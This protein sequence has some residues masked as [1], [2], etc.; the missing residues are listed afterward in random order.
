MRK[1]DINAYNKKLH[2]KIKELQILV[3][4]INP[5][6]I[7][8]FD[9]EVLDAAENYVQVIKNCTWSGKANFNGI[10]MHK[11]KDMINHLKHSRKT[12]YIKRE[13]IRLDE[14][15]TGLVVDG[16]ARINIPQDYDGRLSFVHPRFLIATTNGYQAHTPWK[17]GSE[18]TG[19][20][21][22]IKNKTS[23]DI[24]CSMTSETEL[25]FNH[26]LY[27]DVFYVLWRQK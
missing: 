24:K 4:K 21:K 1:L 18:T 13:V 14:K 3:K 10:E 26:F 22:V 8:Y 7:R 6:N 12:I 9:A 20:M 25:T 17:Y 11:I 19:E 2:D 16:K 27:L 5:E 15:A 23:I